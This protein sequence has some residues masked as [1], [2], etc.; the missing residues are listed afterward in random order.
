MS[1]KGDEWI[2]TGLLVVG[3]LTSVTAIASWLSEDPTVLLA[4]AAGGGWLLSI[5]LLVMLRRANKHADDLKTELKD[6]QQ[7]IGEWRLVAQ[8]DSE[9]LNMLIVRAVDVPRAVTRRHTSAQ[10][11][12]QEGQVNG[13]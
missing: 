2:S 9:S 11:E 12:P 13:D 6:Y 3:G 1:R 4:F 8:R 5:P 7:Q 10:L